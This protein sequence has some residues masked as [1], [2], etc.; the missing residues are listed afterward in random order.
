LSYTLKLDYGQVL[1]S[2]NIDFLVSKIKSKCNDFK[3]KLIFLIL[4]I[5]TIFPPP[6]PIS[7]AYLNLFIRGFGNWLQN[8]Q[9]NRLTGATVFD[10]NFLLIH[11]IGTF[12]K[13]PGLMVE[14]VGRFV[15]HFE[16]GEN[17][18][19]HFELFTR[20]NIDKFVNLNFGKMF[21]LKKFK[22]FECSNCSNRWKLGLLAVD[23]RMN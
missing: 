9:Q 18:Q 7:M 17:A 10:Q 23:S 4:N 14:F 13:H 19:R 6:Y 20:R 2:Q 3:S 8:C 11:Q 5:S 1:W 21:E 15:C 12:G 16:V 22:P